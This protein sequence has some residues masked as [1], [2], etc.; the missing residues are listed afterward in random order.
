RRS[1]PRSCGF[2]PRTPRSSPACRCPSTRARW[3]GCPHTRP[4]PGA[5][6]WPDRGTEPWGRRERPGDVDERTQSA[7]P[8]GAAAPHPDPWRVSGSAPARRLQ[9]WTELLADTHLAFDVADTP[10][11]P[12]RFDG[13]VTR[14]RFGDL[15][16]VD[17]AAS[18]FFGHRSRALMGGVGESRQPEDI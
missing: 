18:P 5:L 1:P 6:P 4:D 12:E 17:C 3:R 9:S 10:A 7:V 14:R 13:M 11:T 16:L 2:A 15:V 8:R